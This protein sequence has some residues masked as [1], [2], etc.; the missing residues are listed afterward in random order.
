MYLKISR[1]LIIWNRY[2]V[3]VILSYTPNISSARTF[4]FFF[5]CR[6]FFPCCCLVDASPF[7]L[8]EMFHQQGKENSFKKNKGKKNVPIKQKWFYNK[9]FQIKENY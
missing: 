8:G 9:L 7:N 4:W 6:T 5:V 3:E 2:G 1:R